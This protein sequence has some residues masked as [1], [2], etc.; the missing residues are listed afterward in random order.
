MN[1]LNFQKEMKLPVDNF[2]DL[3]NIIRQDLKFKFFLLN[4]ITN[5][6]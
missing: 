1:K 5:I 3:L 2:R 4:S 6:S